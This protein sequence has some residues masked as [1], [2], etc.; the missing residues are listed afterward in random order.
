MGIAGLSEAT[1][2]AHSSPESYSRGRSCYNA[3]VDWLR[4]ARDA[5]RAAGNAAAWQSYL[6]ALKD[7]HRRKY[8]LMGLIQAL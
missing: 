8:K 7:T 6:G 2:R 3:A 4:R 5:Y 1:I